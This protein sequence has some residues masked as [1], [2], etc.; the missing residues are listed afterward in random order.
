MV[1][2]S[3][4]EKAKEA[5]LILQEQL[6]LLTENEGIRLDKARSEREKDEAKGKARGQDLFGSGALGSVSEGVTS[7]A[8]ALQ[9]AREGSLIEQRAQSAADVAGR[10]REIKRSSSEFDKLI[11]ARTDPNSEL[12]KLQRSK[13]REEINRA[14]QGQLGQVRASGNLSQSG[15]TQGLVGDALGGALQAR[16]GLERDILLDGLRSAEDL[17]AQKEV[18]REQGLTKK[19]GLSKSGREEE[20][21]LRDRLEGIQGAIQDDTLRRQLINLDQR[22][23]ELFGRLSTEQNI[24]SQGVAERSG[25]KQQI[26]AE[27][28]QAEATRAQREA[29]SLQAAEIAKPTP[30]VGGGTVICGELYRQGLIDIVTYQGDMAYAKGIS[31]DTVKGYQVWAKAYVECMKV[32]KLA[33]YCAYPIGKS[34]AIEMAYRAGYLKKGSVFGKIISFI[35]EPICN[36]IGKA[37]R[38]FN[39]LTVFGA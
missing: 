20:A 28:G 22:S 15:V 5:K 33:T 23:K 7:E 26:L 9:S 39:K 36:V 21:R 11:A 8:R 12:A 6:K 19:E 2:K 4:E 14:L 30:E 27:I 25:V 10:E 13:G 35:G 18:L 3:A 37:L 38:L 24:V 1:E 31:Q 17:T 29:E 16:S 32:S 34:W